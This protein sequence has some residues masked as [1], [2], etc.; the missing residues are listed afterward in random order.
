MTDGNRELLEAIERTYP[1]LDR[2]RDAA[3][4]GPA[5]GAGSDLAEDDLAWPWV[6]S[7]S[8]ALICLGAAREHLH[9][10]RLLIRAGELFP[11]AWSTLARTAVVGGATATWTLVPDER[12]ERLRRS[13]SVVHEDY[14]QHIKFGEQLLGIGAPD[15]IQDTAAEQLARLRLRREEADQLLSSLGGRLPINLTDVVIPAAVDAA[16]FT[17]Q[18]RTMVRMQWRSMSGAA[19]SLIWQHFG[20]PG[21]TAADLDSS[22]VGRVEVGGD[23]QSLAMA[24]F[25]GYHLARAGWSLYERRS[26]AHG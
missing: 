15:D 9:A 14:N 21:T 8:V 13:L 1:D 3:A 17:A 7:S 6:P 24:Y 11:S 20:T 10:I 4:A 5:L 26:Q 16:P 25:S 23:V 12:E 2:W 19:H 22:G 18:Q